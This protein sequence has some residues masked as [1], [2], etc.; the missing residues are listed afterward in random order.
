MLSL[1]ARKQNHFGPVYSGA[2]RPGWNRISGSESE[3]KETTMLQQVENGTP[4]EN[5]LGPQGGVMEQMRAIRASLE[6]MEKILRSVYEITE[7]KATSF[8]RRSPRAVKPAS[9]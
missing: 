5:T 7:T 2:A 8:A 6:S 1:L 9:R 3:G 4:R